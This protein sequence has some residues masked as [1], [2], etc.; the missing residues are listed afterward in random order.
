MRWYYKLA[1]IAFGIFLAFIAVSAVIGAVVG[2]VLGLVLKV[3]IAALVVGGVVYAVKRARSRQH[4]S[5]KKADREVR[6][7]EYS[8]PLPRADVDHGSAPFPPPARPA[9]HDVDDDLAR[10]KR[11]MGSLA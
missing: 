2:F 4:V 3:A 1:G 9:A 10:L 5:G 6:E 11:E 7:P 8:R